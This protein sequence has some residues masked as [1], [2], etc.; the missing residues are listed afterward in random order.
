[1][2]C[3]PEIGLIVPVHGVAFAETLAAARAAE[4]AGLAAVWVPDH[5]L[6]AGRPRAGVLLCEPVLAALAAV[7]ARIGLGTLVLTTAFRHPA[8]L[9]KEI[10]TVES[11]APGRVTLGLGAGGFTYEAT[12][13]QFG[14]PRLAP[15]ERVAHVEETLG[16]LRA[17]WGGDPAGFQGRFVRAADVRIHPRPARPIPIVLA[18]RRPRM[19]ELTARAADGWSC[20]LPHEL[21]AGLAA[22]ERLGRSRDSIAVSAFAVAVLGESEAEARRALARAGRAAQAFGDVETHHVFGAPEQA[23]ERL[24]GLARRGAAHVALD[25]RGLP[26]A[27]AVELLARDVLPRLG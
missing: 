3:I 18:A 4:R 5:L 2:A 23:A 14:F 25:V 1:M 8:L 21:E 12:C 15:G 17:L 19:L 7:T 26:A 6:N 24:A 11:L 22:L 13:A 9:A 16:C 20:P 10:A 27:E